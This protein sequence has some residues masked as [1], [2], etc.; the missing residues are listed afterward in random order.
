MNS[1]YL[2]TMAISHVVAVLPTV[3]MSVHSLSRIGSFGR[4]AIFY[5]LPLRKP[6]FRKLSVPA[7]SPAHR[8]VCL[9][10]VEELPPKL[11]N[12]V[13]LF[14][15]VSEPRSKYEQLLHYGKNM[16]P[17]AKEFQTT[18]NKVEGCVSQV[19]VRAFMDD[20]KVYYEADSDSALTK[21]LAALLV[22]GL[23]GCSPAEI[24]RLTPD[25]IQMLGLRQ[26][27]TASRNSG[28]LNMLKLMQ[29][30]AL[31]L[32]MEA[33]SAGDSNVVDP[34]IQEA[35]G[36]HVL[37]PKE[38]TELRHVDGFDEK[39]NSFAVSAVL[40][41]ADRIRQRLETELEPMVLEIDDISHQHAGHAAVP[42]QARE[43]H[44]NVKIVS[45][46]FEGRSLVKRHR[47]IYELLQEELQS[48]LHALSIIAK[49]PAE[50]EST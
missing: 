18:E 43:T 15:A 25:F 44:F 21:G 34:Q 2:K 31:K 3:T 48:G 20:N 35:N 37:P 47:L 7:V 16:N 46:K 42:D 8:I 40:T 49:T 30:K 19:W 1:I 14:G 5:S 17:L 4:G 6:I 32:Y 39:D 26:S 12:I 13:K 29:K 27:L 50:M 24:L 10:A 28:F 36:V 41:R 11:Q 23:S 9:Q 38:E 45:S 33:E 22:E